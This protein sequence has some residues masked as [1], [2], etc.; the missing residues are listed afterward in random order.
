VGEGGGGGGGGGGGS[1]GGGV[2]SLEVRW[3][4]A[5]GR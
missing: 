2:G 3:C 4:G 1:L 5:D